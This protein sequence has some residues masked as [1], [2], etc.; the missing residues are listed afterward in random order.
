MSS[1]VPVTGSML[2]H[3]PKLRVCAS[4]PIYGVWCVVTAVEFPSPGAVSNVALDHAC[5]TGAVCVGLRAKVMSAARRPEQIA[6]PGGG[7]DCGRDPRH[8]VQWLLLG[9]PAE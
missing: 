6:R 3:S 8:G 2:C 7:P 4:E 1:A 9:G 5:R